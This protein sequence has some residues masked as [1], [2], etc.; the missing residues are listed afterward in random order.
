MYH[1]GFIY[2]NKNTKHKVFL[3]CTTLLTCNYLKIYI[4]IFLIKSNIL[5]FIINNNIFNNKTYKLLK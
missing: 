3:E 1:Y 4:N 2:D 5:S